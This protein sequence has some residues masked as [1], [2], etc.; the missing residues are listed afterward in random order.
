[1]E[2]PGQPPTEDEIRA[3]VR[4][5]EEAVVSL[6]S[7]LLQ[8]I[9]LQAARIQVL[10]DQLA[11][12]SSN[13]GKPPSSD[14]L[15]KATRQRSLRKSSGKKSGAQPGH[16]GHRLEMSA[17]PDRIE[18]YRVARCSHCQAS[19][20]TVAVEQVEKRQEYEWPPL[21]LVVT[22]HQAEV[23]CCP[24]CGH[25]TQAAFPASLTQPTQ[26]GC[27]FKALL[28]YLN[29]KHFIPLARV[30]EFCEDIFQ[31]SAGAGT[32]VAANQRVAEMVEPVNRR[33]QQYLIE[34]E[35]TVHF[36]ESGLRVNQ[37]LHW[38]HSASTLGL[39]YYHVDRKRGPEGINRA[40]ILPKRTGNSRHDDWKPYYSYRDAQHNACNV[41]LAGA[42]FS[43]GTLSTR[44]GRRDGQ[45]P[46]SDQGGGCRSTD[47]GTSWA[48]R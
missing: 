4:R 27:G 22:E 7:D 39:T 43:S 35:E 37:Q 47:P 2:P 38:V 13:S 12:N 10:E 33:V 36:D 11:K 40:G 17:N 8:I 9:Q 30:N 41:S 23:K 29:Q 31:H 3:V 1:M 14:G 48:D 28:I 42:G 44:L 34:T 15:K 45:T 18:R 21:R 25:T 46:R 20:E 26:Y 6:I 5:G 32:I 16:E 24:H 19:L